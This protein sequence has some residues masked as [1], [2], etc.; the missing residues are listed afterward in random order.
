MSL[1]IYLTF[2]QGRDSLCIDFNKDTP[3]HLRKNI[4]EKINPENVKKGVMLEKLEKLQKKGSIEKFDPIN[5]EKLKIL[6]NKKKYK[7]ADA[8]FVSDDNDED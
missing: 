4:F 6:N 5:E 2:V 3:A 1:N 8:G 7:V